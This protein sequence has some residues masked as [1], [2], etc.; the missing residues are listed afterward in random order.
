LT[1]DYL[2]TTPAG[3]LRGALRDDVLNRNHSAT[4]IDTALTLLRS[5]GLAEFEKVGKEENN[6]PKVLWFATEHREVALARYKNVEVR[7]VD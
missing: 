5:E 6:K 7:V 4:D 2:K 3:V 1:F